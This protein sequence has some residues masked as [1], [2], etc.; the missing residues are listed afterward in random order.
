MTN[1]LISDFQSATNH[2]L[3]IF[4]LVSKISIFSMFMYLIYKQMP[5]NNNT[6]TF[7]KKSDKNEKI[8][9]KM[10]FLDFR[11]SF[12][13]PNWLF[14][15]AYT[16]M[17]PRPIMKFI[18]E[19]IELE[20]KAVFSFDWVVDSIPNMKYER[21]LVIMHGI[22]GGSETNYVRELIEGF[23]R[24]KKYKIVV[25]QNRGINDT[26]LFT[27]YPFHC[28]YYQDMG[29]AL[30]LIKERY[31]GLICNVVGVSAGANL[32]TFLL[33]ND[34]EINKYVK[35]FVSIS[36][37]L[38]LKE[39]ADAVSSSIIKHVIKDSLAVYIER[40]PIFKCNKGK[41]IKYILF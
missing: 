24:T 26:P 31:P 17:H 29:I 36:N 11:P 25:F 32:F 18:R 20:D 40:Q 12:F 38:N 15:V 7:Y 34:L 41:Y 8:L 21:I 9:K 19:Y 2:A 22:A 30:N 5:Q 33:A 14:Q 39:S 16:A 1:Y 3:G 37:P 6:W 13:L 4:I 10:G 28:S 35:S 27:P 23:Q